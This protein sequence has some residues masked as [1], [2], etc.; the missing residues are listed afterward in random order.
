MKKKLLSPHLAN[1]FH[2][3]PMLWARQHVFREAVPE[4]A[5]GETVQD[6]VALRFGSAWHATLHRWFR[7]GKLTVDA[8]FAIW[9]EASSI[10]FGWYKQNVYARAL[11]LSATPHLASLPAK[12]TS[13]SLLRAPLALETTL[14]TSLP[15]GWEISGRIDAA[16]QHGAPTEANGGGILEVV[17]WKSGSVAKTEADLRNDVQMRTYALL[18][19]DRWKVDRV[20]VTLHYVM[21]GQR[22]SVMFTRQQIEVPVK[23]RY[24]RIADAIDRKVFKQVNDDRCFTCPYTRAGKPCVGAPTSPS[25]SAGVNP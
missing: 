13:T 24:E 18:A 17:D 20:Q 7:E 10:H 19:M 3:C 11:A 4:E 6:E 1:D 12:L 16:W 22:V 8:L 14:R 21:L 15:G 9:I 2:R 25:V 23:A 5:W